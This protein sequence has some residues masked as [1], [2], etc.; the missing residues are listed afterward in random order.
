MVLIVGR[1]PSVAQPEPD[2][3]SGRDMADREASRLR[4]DVA[5]TLV[6]SR[7]YS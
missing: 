6:I 3:W 7:E 5:Y 2:G 4:A 1:V